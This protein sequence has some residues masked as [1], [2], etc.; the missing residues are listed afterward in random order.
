MTTTIGTATL[1][2]AAGPTARSVT[3][4]A[5]G[6]VVVV[7]ALVIT[8]FLIAAYVGTGARDP[9][10][11]AAYTPDG[12]H[13][14]TALLADRGVPVRR[15]ETVDAVERRADTTVFVPIAQA[16]SSVELG[17]LAGAPGRLVVVGATG[18]QLDAIATDVS[19]A[20]ETD[21][22]SRD[23]ACT[24]PAAVRAGDVEIGGITYRTDGNAT[25]CYAAS[26][27]ATLVQLDRLTLLGSAD[28]F[29]N[30]RLDRHGNA[31]LA[32]G[33]LGA[34]SDV[35]WLLPRPGARNVNS[36]RSLNDLV[37]WPLKLAVL[38]LF[39]AVGVLALWRARRLGAVV[40]E[41]LP[42]VVRAAEAVE[43]RSRLY[44]A[45][46]SRATAAEALR[47]GARDRLARRLGLG[48]ET[49]RQGLVTAVVAHTGGNPAGVDALLYG[50]APTS[51][52]ALVELA[53]NLDI[54]I[55]EVAGS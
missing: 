28:L 34:G 20:A 29:T 1:S 19:H 5:R 6:P 49:S 24:L 53:D 10:D 15:V 55:L 41:P 16:L 43:G 30:A 2:T 37:P 25:G 47:A 7:L 38:Q 40:T 46:R 13:A 22:Q 26:G 18:S 8:G 31:A 3:R 11:P 44:R 23:P 48:L 39:V 4:S 27:Q 45:S 51:D 17:R 52:D 9:L 12:A 42:V 54:L 21:V 14:I 33:L 50:A 36:D 32:L 35:Q